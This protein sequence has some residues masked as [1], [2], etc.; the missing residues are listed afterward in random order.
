VAKLLILTSSI[1]TVLLGWAGLLVVLVVA[2][3]GD[4]IKQTPMLFG[5]AVGLVLLLHLW[6]AAAT[7]RGQRF[8]GLRAIWLGTLLVTL[9]CWATALTIGIVLLPAVAAAWLSAAA[10][11]VDAALGAR[12][13]PSN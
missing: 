1:V 5:V 10:A 9:A 12:R 11:S 3:R 2:W 13:L 7:V 6:G 4:D 8:A